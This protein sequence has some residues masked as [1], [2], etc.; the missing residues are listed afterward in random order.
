ME[1]KETNFLRFLNRPM[2][3]T[4]PIYQRTYSWKLKE[5]EQLW[6]DILKA[7]NN[8]EISGHFVGSIVYVEKGIYQVS[9]LPRL[10]VIDG[11]QRLT[12]LSL[13]ISAFCDHL[14]KNNIKTEINPDK[15]LSY[16]ILNSQEE[17]EEKYKLVL[18]QKD[19]TSFF[20]IIEKLD[21]NE[22][23]SIRIKENYEYFKEQIAKTDIETIYKGI[24]KLI[25]IDVSLDREK[26]NPQ[27]IFE[28]LNSTGLELTQADL[29]RNYILMGLEKQ[30]QED[31]YKNY[32][33]PMEKGFGHTENT[34]LFDRFMRDYLTIKLGRIPTIKEIYS[35][36]KQYSSKFKDI[37][38]VIEDIF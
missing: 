7:G 23:D 8:E 2:Q 29:V 20:K 35:E 36:F 18:T 21:F 4:I 3:L 6:K 31:L 5:C 27:L 26:D 16:Y 25:I 33:H 13:L 1:A 34:G 32:W 10:L 11:Q 30:K 9:A 37:N 38:E 15:L 12:T 17:G 24:S 19:K 14:K 28:S 22:E